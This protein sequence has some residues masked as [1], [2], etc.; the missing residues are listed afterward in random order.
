MP[1]DP[2]GLISKPKV[3]FAGIG[4]TLPFRETLPM[5]KPKQVPLK[6]FKL[7]FYFLYLSYKYGTSC[8]AFNY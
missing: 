6:F 7:Y 8:N 2:F 5:A 1:L 3:C 4:K